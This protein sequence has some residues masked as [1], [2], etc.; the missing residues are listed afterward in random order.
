[1]KKKT[2]YSDKY[3]KIVTEGE[4][5][6]ERKSPGVTFAAAP[7]E[8]APVAEVEEAPKADKK[9]SKKSDSKE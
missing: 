8:A 6:E 7:V 9:K 2:Q 3:G 4:V 1:M 5:V